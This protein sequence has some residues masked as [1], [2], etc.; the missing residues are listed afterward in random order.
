MKCQSKRS[1]SLKSKRD[2]E[3]LIGSERRPEV[4][5]RRRPSRGRPWRRVLRGCGARDRRGPVARQ[6]IDRRS[7]RSRWRARGRSV[8]RRDIADVPGG[9]GCRTSPALMIPHWRA[10]SS[11]LQIPACM[12]FVFG[13]MPPRSCSRYGFAP[14]VVSAFGGVQPPA[15]LSS[16]GHA[17][18]HAFMVAGSPD[19]KSIVSGSGDGTVRLWDSEPPG[20]RY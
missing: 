20:P 18:A 9:V 17:G 11:C 10:K 14:C 8:W 19:G 15:C 16:H 7:L 4:L 13:G 6:S 3:L 1:A 12:L 5:G 2:L